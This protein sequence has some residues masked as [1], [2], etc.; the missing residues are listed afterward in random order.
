MKKRKRV[1]IELERLK[2]LCLSVD[3]GI[4]GYAR[5]LVEA[6]SCELQK[7]HKF[8]THKFRIQLAERGLTGAIPDTN[9]GDK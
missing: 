8:D 1:T 9:G 7:R 5:D 3:Y 2:M 6:I 4:E